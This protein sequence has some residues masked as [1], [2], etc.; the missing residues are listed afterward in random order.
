MLI[1]ESPADGLERC[2]AETHPQKLADLIRRD[3]GLVIKQF[4]SPEAVRRLNAELDPHVNARMPG[5]R[6]HTHDED[7]YG[8]NTKR[9]QG[10]A[11]K[12]PSFVD[13]VLLHST[14]LSIA[15]EVLLPYCGDY[16]MS[17][18]ETIFIG[19]GNR[20]Q[21][22]HRDDVNWEIPSRLGIDLQVSVLVAL[23]DY[24][25]EVGATMVV[26]GSHEWP[27]DRVADPSEARPVEMEPGD[28]LVYLGSLVHGGG[29]NRTPDRWRRALYVAYLVGWLTPEE[30]VAVSI[31]PDHARTLPARAQELLGY[32]NLRGLEHD[33]GTRTTLELWQ[34]DAADFD[35]LDGAFRHR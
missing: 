28:A 23:G 6:E 15:D 8:S 9:I 30:A 34:L 17:Q 35:R 1:P 31:G 20:A 7:F 12:A 18:A 16:W 14:A 24:D 27:L 3:G 26:P 13:E 4:I 2:S 29:H 11:A 19:P 21:E 25:A 33:D 32:A 22:L 5:F 10:L